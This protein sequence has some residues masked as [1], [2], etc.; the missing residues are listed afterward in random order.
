MNYARN[1]RLRPAMVTSMPNQRQEENNAT[2]MKS[3]GRENPSNWRELGIE[4]RNVTVCY[5]KN[6]QRLMPSYANCWSDSGTS[7]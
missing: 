7:I 6:P 2:L 3:D 4:I 5:N 1:L